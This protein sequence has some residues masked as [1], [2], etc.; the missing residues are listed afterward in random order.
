MRILCVSA[1]HAGNGGRMRSPIADRQPKMNKNMSKPNIFCRAITPRIPPLS[2]ARMTGSNAVNKSHSA[3]T[4][5]VA[6]DYSP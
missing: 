1:Y 5:G 4:V 2:T 3:G 6:R